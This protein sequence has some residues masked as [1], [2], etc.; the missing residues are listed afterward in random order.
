MYIRK[1]SFFEIIFISTAVFFVCMGTSFIDDMGASN[2]RWIFVFLLFLYLFL[3]KKLLI[4]VRYQWKVLLLIYLTWCILTTLWSPIPLLTFLK[5]ALFSFNV[6]VLLSAGCLWV[7]K[8]GYERSLQWLFLILLTVLV[9]GLR[10][11]ASAGSL[12]YYGAFN[13]YSGLNGNANAFGFLTAIVSPLIF[14]KIYQNR[15]SRWSFFFWIFVLILD[16]HFLIASYS[17]SSFV[18]FSC[19]LACFTLSFPLTKKILIAF[20]SFF[21]LSIVLLMMPVSYLEGMIVNHI[22]KSRGSINSFNLNGIIQ[23][24]D[25]V[26]KQSVARAER[27]GF[28][29]GGFAATI[30]INDFSAKELSSQVSAKYGHE[31]GNSQL[32]IMEETGIIGIV[33]YALILISFFSCAI[34]CY[35]RLQGV[36]RVTMGTTLGAILGLLMESLV[37]GWWDSAAGPEVI[38]FWTLVGII[39]GM[40]YLQKR[41]SYDADIQ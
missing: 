24:R 15:A 21:C 33:L 4:Y 1:R 26:W 29:G 19:V 11:G 10:G 27:G 6:I 32:A 14:L 23:S 30:G 17:R 35:L 3:N 13:L 34:P 5:S 8:Y 9:S 25:S 7:I 41:K 31:K 37:E 38:C 28:M 12:D 36:E 40:I 39:Y 18:I 2:L 16:I 20:L 22:G